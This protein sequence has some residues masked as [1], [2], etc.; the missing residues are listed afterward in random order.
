LAPVDVDRLAGEEVGSVQRRELG[1]RG[2]LIG[3]STLP[4]GLTLASAS[5]S[6]S[7]RNCSESATAALAA[8]Y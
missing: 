6:T 7:A 5:A 8:L 3:L 1:H 4:S 2:Y